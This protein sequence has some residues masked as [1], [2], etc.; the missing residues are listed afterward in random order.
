MGLRFAGFLR[1]LR[2]N[3]KGNILLMAGAALTGL[4]GAAGIGVDTV[5]WYLWKR[6]MQQ[7][8][9]TGA[10]AGALMK[11]QGRAHED[12]VK[13]ELGRTANTAYAVEGINTPPLTGAFAGNNAAVEV[14]AN[15][16]SKLPFSSV[17]MATP[18]LIRT[19]AVAMAVSVGEPCVIGLATSGIGVE[20]SG[21]ANVS[22]DCPVA[23]NSPSGVSID[24]NGGA[25]LDTDLI[26]SV[27][28]IDYST[29]NLPA[30]AAIVTYGLPV[31]DPLASRGLTPPASPSACHANNYKIN[32]SDTET[33]PGGKRWCNGLTIQGTAYLEGGV[34]II[35]RGEFKVNSGAKVL[36]AGSGG[37]TIIL[38]GNTSSNIAEL[39]ING[40]AEIDLRAPTSTENATWGGILFYQDPAGTAT[41][42]INGGADIDLEGIIYM[43]T[44]DLTY[45]GSATQDA[46]CLLLIT[47]RVKFGGSNNIEN[48]CNSDVDA[49]NASVRVVRVVE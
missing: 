18:P 6:Q 13:S 4:I 28:G 49:V 21:S 25:Y 26:N 16:S 19:R 22:L 38:T 11:T 30:D 9:D 45:S 12:A 20:V 2:R 24:F 5:Q 42:T 37:V 31:E 41:H 47:E 3:E 14:I 48:N 10:V 35:D 43:P 34:Y 36:L 15:T 33:L 27:G 23:S 44:G 1:R 46:Q 7:A 40:G 32:P 39:A 17:F 29:T 8:V